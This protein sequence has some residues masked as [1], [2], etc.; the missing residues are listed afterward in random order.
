MK[1]CKTCQ[2]ELP[3]TEFYFHKQTNCY[4]SYCKLCDNNKSK[5]YRIKNKEKLN[6]YAKLYRICK[7]EYL[8]SWFKNYRQ[9][10]K[11]IINKRNSKY[12]KDK[13]KTDSNFKLLKNIRWRTWSTLKNKQNSS[14]NLLMCS[15]K[16]LK[17][18]LEQQF[19]PGMTWNNY[20]SVWE[21][22]HIIPCAFFK[23]YIKD[24]VEQY[25]C[26][27]YQNLQ[28]LFIKENS[29]KSNKINNYHLY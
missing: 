29:K 13:C 19:K 6:E 11:T 27:R 5:Q 17:I 25:M 14:I 12:I 21:I 1:K 23:D 26:F 22:D 24:P 10:N 20:G 15:L 3:K 4:S 9:K 28:P 16:Q 7:K 18:H 2:R 8:K